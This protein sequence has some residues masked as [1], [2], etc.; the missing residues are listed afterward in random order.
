MAN[1]IA[2][3]RLLINDPA[4]ANQVFDD[5][6][7]QNVL[8]ESRQDLYN[9]PLEP[10]PTF[11]GAT[12]LYLDYLSPSQLGDWEDDIVLKQY[13][14]VVVTPSLIDDIV[15]HYTFAQSTFPPVY[16][17][18]KTFDLYRSAAD[19]LVR[20]AARWAM[21]FNATADGQTLHLEGVSTNLLNL[22]K[23]YRAKQRIGVTTMTRSDLQQPA[24]ASSGVNLDPRPIDFMSSG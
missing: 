14:T 5:Q 23:Q 17:T 7:V 16:I 24:G 18:G 20:M 10:K 3:T 12:I 21:R 13:M 19:L 2:R 22:A 15:G 4:G 11:S 6:T 8:D 1:L 9:L